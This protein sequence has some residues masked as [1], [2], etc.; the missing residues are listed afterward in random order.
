MIISDIHLINVTIVTNQTL[1]QIEF[2]ANYN[3]SQFTIQLS[4]KPLNDCKTRAL[5]F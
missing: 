2:T 3:E 1:S 4:L 5:R